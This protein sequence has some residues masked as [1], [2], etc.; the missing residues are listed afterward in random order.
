MVSHALCRSVSVNF[1]G[2]K[3]WD[4]K[5]DT[6]R[7][8]AIIE[9]EAAREALPDTPIPKW[10]LI[11]YDDPKPVFFGH[12]W[13]SGVPEPLAPNVACVDYSVGKGGPLVAYG[14]EGESELSASGFVST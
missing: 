12:Y 6:Y 11:G 10:A 8:A 7:K 4:T 9:P 3:W 13:F 2:N 5:A 14:W 1:A